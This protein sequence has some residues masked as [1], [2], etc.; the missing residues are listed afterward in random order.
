[1]GINETTGDNLI[2]KV[3]NREAFERNFDAIF[4]KKEDRPKERKSQEW[5]K[6][7]IDNVECQKWE[8]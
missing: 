6:P 7:E 2:S 8:S 5:I 3:G 4:G 1:M